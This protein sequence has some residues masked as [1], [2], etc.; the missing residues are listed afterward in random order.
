M[1]DVGGNQGQDA[2]RKEGEEPGAESYQKRKVLRIQENQTSTA[3]NWSRE[4]SE[5]QDHPLVDTGQGYPS[6]TQ[7]WLSTGVRRRGQVSNPITHLA[8]RLDP[9]IV[10]RHREHRE[11]A[12][13]D[14]WPQ[15]LVL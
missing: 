9:G 8:T 3:K 11:R 7:A 10:E 13:L 15:E 12:A 14:S 6:P 4:D 2:G 1:A 5:R